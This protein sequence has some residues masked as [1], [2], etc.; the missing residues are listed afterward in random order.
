MPLSSAADSAGC[1]AVFAQGWRVRLKP[2]WGVDDDRSFC[3]AVCSPPL[4]R[5]IILHFSV[6]TL[7]L[8]IFYQ[9]P[10]SPLGNSEF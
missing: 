9:S 7:R 1:A 6:I 5:L 4:P 2:P 8:F 3:T 10:A